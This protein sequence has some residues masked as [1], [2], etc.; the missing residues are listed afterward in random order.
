MGKEKSIFVL[1]MLVA[2]LAGSA[3]AAGIGDWPILWQSQ[4]LTDDSPLIANACKIYETPQAVTEKWLPPTLVAFALIT[5]LI[6]LAYV[7]SG[8]QGGVSQSGVFAPGGGQFFFAT[9]FTTTKVRA[10]FKDAL[11]GVIT[12]AIIITM[13]TASY[14]GLDAFGRNY[15]SKALWYG[16]TVRNTLIGISG[17]LRGS[18]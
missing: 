5:G 11:W 10:W 14:G 1:A 13:F 17:C 18:R 9:Q 7:L 16:N 12:T 2:L 15:I 8:L 3:R 6:A 4:T